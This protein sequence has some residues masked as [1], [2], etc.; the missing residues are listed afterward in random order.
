M[1]NQGDQKKVDTYEANIEI[2]LW[3]S[4]SH[5]WRTQ[6]NLPTYAL[7]SHQKDR[8]ASIYIFCTSC[9]TTSIIIWFLYHLSHN[10]RYASMVI[11]KFISVYIPNEKTNR[12]FVINPSKI[13]GKT[14]CLFFSN[15]S[16]VRSFDRF[17]ILVIEKANNIIE[18][19]RKEK[20]SIRWKKLDY[21]KE[22]INNMVLGDT[23]TCVYKFKVE[24]KE[25]DNTQIIQHFVMYGLGLCIKINNYVAHLF[26]YCSFSYNT[27]IPISLK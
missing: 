19:L 8:Q 9:T 18:I 12:K 11:D 6:F 1:I 2:F 3:D 5:I 14:L 10:I 27:A 20:P 16:Y 13:L 21:T 15:T 17:R 4:S 22:F 23:I 7:K 25:M 24:K 26:Y